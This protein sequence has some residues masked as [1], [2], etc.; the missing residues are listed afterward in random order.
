MTRKKNV[1]TKSLRIKGHGDYTTENSIQDPSKRLEAK[2]DAI[3]R[4]VSKKSVSGAASTIGRTLG[5]FVNQGDLGAIAGSSLAKLFG[6]GDFQVKSNSLVH[7]FSE[8]SSLPKFSQNGKR[9]TRIVEREYLGDIVA[10]TLASGSTAFSLSS[11]A[12]NPTVAATFPWLSTL[13]YQYD[14]WEPHGIVFEFISTSSEYNGSSQSLGTVIMA[15][16]YDTIDATYSNK[17]VMENADY[18]AS[19]KPSGSLMHGVECAVAERP[20]PVMYTGTHSNVT[21]PRLSTLG[22]FQIA[23]VGMS[24]TGVT[25]G[26]LWVSYDITFYKKQITKPPYIEPCLNISGTSV[27]G[28]PMLYSPTGYA[29]YIDPTSYTTDRIYNAVNSNNTASIVSFDKSVP[30]GRYMF[31]FIQGNFQS[32]VIFTTFVNCTSPYFESSPSPG[33]IGALRMYQVV[34]Q[35]DKPWLGASVSF[36]LKLTAAGY[37]K[38]LVT[39]VRD[40]INNS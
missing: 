34:V 21:D 14:Q 5:N 7:G 28:Q 32:E 19:T 12:I 16:D 33:T 18:S 29:T 20:L 38:L 30:A 3:E 22:N 1:K 31:T 2:I 37:F 15:T 26:E 6:H 36:P 8:S 11:F 40:N 35:I 13:A 24:A 17:Q 25:V 27:V 10:G 4:A 23:T 39:Q 9:G